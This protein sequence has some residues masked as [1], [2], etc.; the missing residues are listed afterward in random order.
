MF[1]VGHIIPQRSA[2]SSFAFC[3]MCHIFMRFGQKRPLAPRA[4][5]QAHQRR[6]FPSAKPKPHAGHHVA[7][8]VQPSQ[9][10]A[11]RC[12]GGNLQPI[13]MAMRKYWK[14]STSRRCG[15]PDWNTN[16]LCSGSPT[17]PIPIAAGRVP[18][19]TIRRKVA[20]GGEELHD[21]HG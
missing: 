8:V 19:R 2:F 9:T 20:A 7:P 14:S 6:L 12:V 3:N 4:Y 18:R 16:R 21:R 13:Q 10:G 17:W 11:R 5:V 1:P 15:R